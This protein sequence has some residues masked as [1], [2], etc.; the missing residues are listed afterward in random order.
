[1][2]QKINF[3]DA[4][5][6]LDAEIKKLESGNMSLDESIESFESAIRL[7]RVCNERLTLAEQRVRLLVEGVDGSI[8]DTAFI[9]MS[10]ET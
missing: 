9:G 2:E 4:M 3:E 1:M 10:D 5:E 6:K 8:S 7:I